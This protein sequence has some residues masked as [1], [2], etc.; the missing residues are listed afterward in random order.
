MEI[1]GKGPQV[2]DVVRGPQRQKEVWEESQRSEN[3]C[4]TAEV[5]V[6]R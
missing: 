2:S 6:L 5:M 4:Q 1:G 3:A